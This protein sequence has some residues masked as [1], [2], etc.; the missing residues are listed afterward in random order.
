MPNF[1]MCCT[2]FVGSYI[3]AFIIMWRLAL[4]AFPT[5]LLL[6]IP[7]I[8]YGKTLMNLARKIKEESDKTTCVIE[9]AISSIRTVYSF[10]GESKT[11][12]D[13]SVTLNSCVKL[14]L[15]QGLIK[16][17]AIGSSGIS[18]AIWAFVAWYGSKL[19]MYS[20]AHGGNIYAVGIEVTYGGL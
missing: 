4:V 7:G 12:A 11:M 20:G 15:R 8:L 13:F 6:I 10:V 2:I 17:L 14:G 19:I 3:V 18:F 1:I 5:V 9:Q 16:G